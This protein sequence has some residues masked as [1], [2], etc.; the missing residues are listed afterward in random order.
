MRRWAF[1][2]ARAAAMRNAR[3][4]LTGAVAAHMDISAQVAAEKALKDSERRFRA[5]ANVIPH[6][7]ITTL[8]TTVV[9]PMIRSALPLDS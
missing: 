3:G 9:K 5:I 4:E 2:L 8:A 6:H 1:R 7:T